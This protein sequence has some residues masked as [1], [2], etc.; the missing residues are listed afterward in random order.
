MQNR[1]SFHVVMCLLVSLTISC[2]KPLVQQKRLYI[3]SDNHFQVMFF[4]HNNLQYRSTLDREETNYHRLANQ[5]EWKSFKS[6][7][8]E[9]DEMWHWYGASF[10]D[11]KKNPGSEGSCILR[12]NKVVAVFIAAFGVEVI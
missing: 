2:A 3:D 8:L 12:K 4:P 10:P 5:P 6:M 9:G 1:N 11:T 7:V